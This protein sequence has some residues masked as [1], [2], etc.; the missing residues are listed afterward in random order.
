MPRVVNWVKVVQSAINCNTAECCH[1]S[2]CTGGGATQ[3]PAFML[4]L[5]VVDSCRSKNQ[6]PK[7]EK[8][9]VRAVGYGIKNVFIG[10][11][12]E[13]QQHFHLWGNIMQ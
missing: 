1:S 6:T 9:L 4:I 11:T 3:G 13:T 12:G 5:M 2:V 8:K 10:N 7:P